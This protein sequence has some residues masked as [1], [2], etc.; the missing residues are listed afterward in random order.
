MMKTEDLRHGAESKRAR[1]AYE[2]PKP[3]MSACSTSRLLKR[4]LLICFQDG[5]RIGV[6][7]DPRLLF[8]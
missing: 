8:I 5:H 3:P 2:L 6:Y 4:E 7:I 1:S